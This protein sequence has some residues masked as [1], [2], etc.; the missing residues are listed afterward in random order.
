[1]ITQ[2][3]TIF[4]PV[5]DQDRSLE[6]YI[7]KLGFEKR[8]DFVYGGTNR[9][10]E[11]APAGSHVAIALVPRTEGSHRADDHTYCAFSAS[12]IDA[13]HATLHERGVNVDNQIARKGTPREGLLSRDVSIADP[14][15]AQFFMRDLDGNRFLVVESPPS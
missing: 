11:V 4:V 1:M 12:D 9:W 5:A 3:A 14:V 15:P 13:E 10:I 7:E 6:F 8:I 2:V